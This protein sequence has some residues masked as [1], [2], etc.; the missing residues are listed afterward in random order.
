MLSPCKTVV[1][2]Y[3]RGE[4]QGNENNRMLLSLD[5]Q[6]MNNRTKEEACWELHVG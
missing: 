6:N 3:S 2:D 5:L 1:I 4:Q